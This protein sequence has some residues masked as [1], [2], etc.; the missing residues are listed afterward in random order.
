MKQSKNSNKR[1]HLPLQVIQKPKINSIA[2]K[3]VKKMNPQFIKCKGLKGDEDTIKLHK[4][5]KHSLYCN[6][7]I[8]LS[9][10]AAQFE[11]DMNTHGLL[12]KIVRIQQLNNYFESELGMMDKKEA[13][14]PSVKCSFSRRY[15]FPFH[16]RNRSNSPFK[17]GSILNNNNSPMNSPVMIK[18]NFIIGKQISKGCYKADEEFYCELSTDPTN[19]AQNISEEELDSWMYKRIPDNNNEYEYIDEERVSFLHMLNQ[20]E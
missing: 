16:K 14:S 10:Q 5:N 3:A 17:S 2:Q 7:Q 11:I 1:H 19:E 20:V 9:K 15:A 4:S 13:L 18:Q 8:L 12:D 6:E